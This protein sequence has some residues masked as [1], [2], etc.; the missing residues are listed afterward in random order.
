MDP[1]IRFSL[2][3]IVEILVVCVS[4][5]LKAYMEICL[6]VIFVLEPIQQV[7]EQVQEVK[8][9]DQQFQLLP[10][11]NFFMINDQGVEFK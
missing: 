3:E 8:R 1:G 2:M 11:M 9:Q 4:L 6:M 10:E 5:E 7:M